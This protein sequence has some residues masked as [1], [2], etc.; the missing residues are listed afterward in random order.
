MTFEQAIQAN[1]FMLME[2]AII[3]R[4]RRDPH[5]QLHPSLENSL[6]IH[7]PK[8]RAILT[9]LYREYID[10]AQRANV[11]LALCTP[12]WRANQER[13]TAEAVDYDLNANAVQFMQPFKDI[14]PAVFIGGLIGCRNDSYKP[15]EALT[16]QQA[17]DFHAWQIRHLTEADF[18]YAVT[19]PALTEAL[20]IAQA[21]ATTDLPYIISFVV[22]RQG[23]LLD[24]NLLETAIETIDAQTRRP[25]FG[26]GVNCSHPS[27]L[28]AAQCSPAAQA[29]MIAI[30]ANASSLDHV[31]LDQ[32]D[33]LHTGKLEDWGERMIEIHR[34]LGI[35]MLGG[36]CGTDASHLNYL[37]LH[38]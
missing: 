29:R 2:A 16:R 12:T 19:F 4:L 8:D 26:Y 20:G 35:R 3:E 5:A 17:F 18:L 33:T 13:L 11:P 32:A 27:F 9:A 1:P 23:R 14:Y 36:C 31:L 6:L 21:M 38:L 22:D 24:G 7:N 15:E 30:Q 10:I 25:P 28:Q 34:T 37:T